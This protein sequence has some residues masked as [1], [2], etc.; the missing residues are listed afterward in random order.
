MSR[1]LHLES[2]GALYHVTSRCNERKAIL[3][4]EQDFVVI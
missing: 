3:R 2:S 1:P 4:D